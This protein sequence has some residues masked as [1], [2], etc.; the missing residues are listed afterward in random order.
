MSC[1]A[2]SSRREDVDVS[3]Y[4]ACP[5]PHE[6]GSGQSGTHHVDMRNFAPEALV[7]SLVSTCATGPLSYGGRITWRPDEVTLIPPPPGKPKPVASCSKSLD[8]NGKATPSDG[9]QTISLRVGSRPVCRDWD[10]YQGVLSLKVR[11]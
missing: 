3:T 1:A 6:I 11:C 10:E 7:V 8:H 4:V 2:R 9:H 5:V